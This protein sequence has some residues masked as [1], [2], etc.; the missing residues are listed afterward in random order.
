MS[1]N[2]R[3][4]NPDPTGTGHADLSVDA[5]LR[6][7][8]A[9]HDINQMLA[10]IMGRAE[11]LLQREATEPCEEDLKAIVLAAGDA[12]AMLKRLQRG[13]PAQ[14]QDS[15]PPSVSL[16]ETAEAISLLIRPAATGRWGASPAG[17]AGPAW[18]F[19]WDVPADLYTSVPGQVVRE[20]LSNL[21]LN[22]LDVLPGGGRIMLEAM[23]DPGRVVLTVADDG[24]GLDN[25]TARRIFEPGFTSHEG[26]FRGIGLAGSRQL[27]KCF[28]S[29]LDLGPIQGPGARFVLDLPRAA[30][31]PSRTE[32]AQKT[33]QGFRTMGLK[34]LVVDDEPA[35]RDML[36]DVLTEFKCEVI[37]ARNA[38]E[39]LTEFSHGGFA[40]AI[41]D[42]TLP[43]RTG[44]DLASDLREQ[45]EALVVV[46]ISGWGQKE[47]LATVD[48][49][50]ID[51]TENKPL[52]M[53]RIKDIL[54]RASG[55]H[56]QRKSAKG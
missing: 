49:A 40:L 24:P 37:T 39:A 12:A 4:G 3:D 36:S 22:A 8:G 50:L 5:T 51:M 54:V 30:P 6:R 10:V 15:S 17:E 31:P 45:D 43:G 55:L 32:P 33:V 44:L 27:L 34:V 41:L 7:S 28:D 19:Q 2:H 13:L 11:L 53:K 20:V 29:R 14:G 16:R 25:E 18:E 46:L 1:A 48:P 56:D 42:Q 47:V 26:E 35:V 38:S 21:L 52:E 9:V 23:G